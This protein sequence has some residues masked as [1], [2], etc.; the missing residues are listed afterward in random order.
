MKRIKSVQTRFIL[1]FKDRSV[2]EIR[3][4]KYL[5]RKVAFLSRQAFIKTKNREPEI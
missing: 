5:L 2:K 1:S 3:R 4:V